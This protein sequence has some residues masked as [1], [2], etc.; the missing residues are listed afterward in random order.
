MKE[1]RMT[2]AVQVSTR[3]VRHVAVDT[4]R[5]WGELKAA[6]EQVVPHFDRLEAIGVVL[7]DSGWEAITRLSDATATNG[8]V[9]FF[10]FD[11]SPVMALNGHK[12]K[13]VTYLAGNIVKAEAGFAVDPACFLYIPLRIAI[14]ASG[15]ETSASLSFDHPRDLFAAFPPG[16]EAVSTEF[17]E[18]LATILDLLGVP[19]ADLVREAE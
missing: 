15:P 3:S 7:S 5:P 10:T 4:G 19:G 13:G 2:D 8:L 18:T 11:P 9:N 1:G 14:S 6:Y 16:L 12:A 17:V